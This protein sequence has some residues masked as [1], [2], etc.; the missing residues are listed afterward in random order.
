M[1]LQWT[2]W[3]NEQQRCVFC[4]QTAF[5]HTEAPR[6]HLLQ[7]LTSSQSDSLS[8]G[9]RCFD[10]AAKCWPPHTPVQLRCTW[11]LLARCTWSNLGHAQST[12]FYRGRLAIAMCYRATVASKA[13]FKGHILVAALPVRAVQRLCF[14]NINLVNWFFFFFLQVQFWYNEQR[15]AKTQRCISPSQ[16]V[17][18]PHWWSSKFD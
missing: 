4:N 15:S 16:F 18:P 14:K 13:A 3:A 2:V 5:Q 17:L 12:S 8:I 6:Q 11:L 10:S 1:T 7:G 9:S